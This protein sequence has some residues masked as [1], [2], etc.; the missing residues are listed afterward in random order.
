VGLLDGHA[1]GCSTAL[2]GRAVFEKQAHVLHN[3]G[4]WQK[5]SVDGQR[6]EHYS[7]LLTGG[8]ICI[9]RLHYS[10]CSMHCCNEMATR[11]TQ[12]KQNSKTACSTRLQSKTSIP[13]VTCAHRLL[14][15]Q[16]QVAAT[17]PSVTVRN[18]T[19]REATAQA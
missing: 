15:A 10:G 12:A 4:Q 5:I 18:V 7:V 6:L 13:H 8:I 19:S 16:L 2:L 9:E 17:L 1:V 3:G 11:L 14:H